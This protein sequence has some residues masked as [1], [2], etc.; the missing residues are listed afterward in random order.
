VAVFVSFASW[1][2]DCDANTLLPV[3]MHDNARKC[4]IAAEC[5][6]DIRWRLLKLCG[7]VSIRSGMEAKA[8]AKGAMNAK[9]D[10]KRIFKLTFFFAAWFAP[11]VSF[12]VALNW[13]RELRARMEG[14]RC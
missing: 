8:T 10:A 9:A 4:T 2:F 1:W 14:E 11:F 12:A 13:I 5:L 7:G 6:S 3:R